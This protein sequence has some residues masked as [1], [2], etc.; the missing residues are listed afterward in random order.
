MANDVFDKK[1]QRIVGQIRYRPTIATFNGVSVLAKELEAKFEEWRAPKHDDITLYSPKVKK[2]LQVG[3]DT[4]TYLNE[5]EENTQELISYLKPVFEKCTSSLEVNNIRRIGFRNTQ[6]LTCAFKFQ[7][8]N[9]LIFR[10][11]YSGN[12]D[13][14]SISSDL[15]RETVF[16]LDGTKNGFQN[17]VQIGPVNREEALKFYNSGF[18]VDKDSIGDTNLFVDVDVF[19]LEGLNSKNTI[20]RL[21]DS[22]KENLRIIRDYIKYL[23]Q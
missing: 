21:E 15:P 22:V 19:Q 8:L 16:I 2:L 14:K 7:E 12:K 23:T 3:F 20:E 18:D 4:I 1:L 6:I 9:D 17:H 11:F 10:K 13:F 5:S